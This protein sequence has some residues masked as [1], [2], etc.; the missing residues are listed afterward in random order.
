MIVLL[1]AIML[2]A[3]AVGVAGAADVDA[4]DALGRLLRDLP[5][6]TAPSGI[7]VDRAL[8]LAAITELDGSA[9]A[10]PV[11]SRRWR[12]AYHEVRRAADRPQ[13][14]PALSTLRQA[15]ASEKSAPIA[16]SVLDV[17][18][19]RIK[20][21]AFERGSAVV[22]GGS[23]QL[24]PASLLSSDLFTAAAVRDRSFHGERVRFRLG[25]DS[26]FSNRDASPRSMSIDADDGRGFR[27]ING[28]QFTASWLSEGRKTLRL[29][30]EWP[31]GTTRDASFHFDIAGLAAP[32]PD[33]TLRV[34]AS[35]PY[36]GGVASGDAWIYLA[37]GAQH[38][39]GRSSSSRDSTWTT[40]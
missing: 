27:Q 34:T 39:P 8:P 25:Q 17:R 28:R 19:E 3:G 35:T 5:T 16:I 24:Q 37:D 21:D 7:L 13:D 40:R 9:A 33:D 2:L 15:W 26:W 29:R 18:Y 11:S 32:A 30:A 20:P 22:R 12:Q 23:I 36:L 31:D 4:G 1:V 10:P 38:S 14:W 6:G